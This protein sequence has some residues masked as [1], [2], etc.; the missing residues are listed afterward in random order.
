MRYEEFHP[1]EPLS[2]LVKCVWIMESTAGGS[3]KHERIV[4]DGCT[5]IVFNLADPFEQLCADGSRERQPLTLLVG[6]MQRPVLIGPT[7]RVHLLGIRFWPAGAHPL[8]RIPQNEIANQVLNLDCVLG[9]FARELQSRIA[10]ANSVTERMRVVHAALCERLNDVRNEDR[11]VF[12]ATRFILRTGG[13]LSIRELAFRIGINPR[14]LDRRFNECVGVS[15][16]SLS[17]IVRFQQVLRMVQAN[18][19][20]WETGAQDWARVAVEC[21]YY[22]Q[23]HFIREFKTFA[24]KEPTSYFAEENA[25]SDHFTAA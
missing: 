19:I 1:P 16:K 3:D 23:P 4:P 13:R 12:A 9:G 24:G 15:P 8:L 22:D 11:A 18:A 5:E 25:M 7:G 17:R 21:G 20:E 10:E 6:Q 14:T 2:K